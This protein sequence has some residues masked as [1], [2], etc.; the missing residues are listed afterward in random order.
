MFVQRSYVLVTVGVTMVTFLYMCYKYQHGEVKQHLATEI[1]NKEPT[2]KDIVI[3]SC[4]DP[5]END[6]KR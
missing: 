6:S 4:A 5:E 3:Q 2:E 1:M